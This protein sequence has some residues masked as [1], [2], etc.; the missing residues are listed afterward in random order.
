MSS[1]RLALP[2]HRL[3]AE[4]A[5]CNVHVRYGSQTVLQNTSLDLHHGEIVVLV[6]A[7]GSG[8]STLL[9]TIAG[10]LPP[11]SGEIVVEGHPVTGPH[12]D[13]ALIF[14]DDA[15]LPWLTVAGNVQLPLSLRKV[16]K[17]QRKESAA[18]WI[19]R[20]GLTDHADLLPRQLSGG[21]RQRAQLARALVTQP[22]VLLMDEP[23]GALDAQSRAAMQHLLLDVWSRTPTTVLFVTHD[24]DEALLLAHRIVVLGESRTG[25]GIVDDIHLTGP[26]STDDTQ[27]ARDRIHVALGT[28]RRQP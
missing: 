25:S 22:R 3:G 23:F 10:L 18:A 16:G 21:M 1:S 15:L 8:K 13:R 7:S 2:E 27:Q 28:A 6:G 19:D 4:L 26:E 9:R 12:R 5:V 14:Q 20:V 24:V 11:D 17:Q